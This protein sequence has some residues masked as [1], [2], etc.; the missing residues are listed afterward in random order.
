MIAG[1]MKPMCISETLVHRAQYLSSSQAL[2]G[3][4][5]QAALGTKMFSRWFQQQF[6]ELP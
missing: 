1:G 4:E 2:V 5:R 3:Q 6:G